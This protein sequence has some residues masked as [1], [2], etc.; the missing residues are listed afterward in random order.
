MIEATYNVKHKLILKLLYGCGLRVS[1]V[2]NLYKRDLDFNDKLIHVKLS[3][4]KKDR[5]V[6]I[7][8]KLYEELKNYCA[9]NQEEMVFP[10]N[11]GGKL[12]TATIQAI[13][14]KAAKKAGITKEVYPHLLRHCFATHMLENG[15]NIRILQELLGHA[16]VKTTE[17]YTHVMARDIRQLQSPLDRL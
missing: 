13:V 6:K 1:E 15:V 12:T 17:I 14:E 8:E 3:K 16:D 4:G 7:P 9:L 5:F 11:R 2:V 10:S